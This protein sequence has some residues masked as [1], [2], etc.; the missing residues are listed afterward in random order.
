MIFNLYPK[1][2]LRCRL[3]LFIAATAFVVAGTS[4]AEPDG[5]P[6]AADPAAKRRPAET[7]AVL[8]LDDELEPFVPI[9]AR[10]ETEAERIEALSLFAAGRVD[11]QEDR[12]YQA[13][14]RYQRATRF[15]PSSQAARLQAVVLAIRLG[16]D[17]SPD[18][19]KE[20]HWN[21]ALRYAAASDLGI[22]EAGVLWKIA[23]HFAQREQYAEALRY[24]RSARELQDKRS[25]GYVILS[26]DVGR[27]AV[28]TSDF[29][30]AADVFTEVADALE[31]PDQY[32]LDEG[33]KRRLLGGKDSS[34]GLSQL[35]QLFAEAYLSAQRFDEAVASL[36]KA[37]E[38]KPDAA[39]H[40]FRLARVEDVRKQPAKSLELLKRY[41]S[42]KASSQGLAPYQLYVKLQND[43]SRGNDVISGLAELHER[44]PDN[45]LLAFFLAE[46]YRAAEQFDKAQPLYTAV[47][48]KSPSSDAYQGLAA[49]ERRLKQIANL[50]SLL[51]D[52]AGKTGSLEALEGETKAIVGDSELVASLVQLARDRHTADADNL[53]FGER[54]AVAIIALEAEQFDVAKEFFELAM[55]VNRDRASA[56]YRTWAIG[57]F[58]E[59]RYA[60]AVSVF[61]RA[62]DE[63]AVASGDP[64]FHFLLSRALAADRKLDEALIAAKHV[65]SLAPQ[66]LR[67]ATWLA[68]VLSLSKQYDEAKATCERTLRRHDEDDQSD[69]ARQLLRQLRIMLSNIAVI[70]HDLPASEE[71]L[72]QV[73]D[74]FPDDVGAQNDLGYLWADGGKHLKMAQGMIERAVAAEPDNAAY[75]DSLGW[76]YYRLGRYDDAVAEL[77]KAAAGDEPDGVMLEH[78]GDAC[79][80]AGQRDA[81]RDAWQKG[82]AALEKGDDAEKLAQ[83]KQKLADLEKP[84]NVKDNER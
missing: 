50:V 22:D 43:L 67:A 44:D 46:R 16:D 13:L 6:D 52:V 72:S 79:L 61:K 14:R 15:D 32:G 28:L 48:A 40:A 59:E 51:G 41:F 70:Q 18:R 78:L 65:A 17:D 7:A 11:E 42:E 1:A 55:K 47:L 75:R 8:D 82:L 58:G 84:A 20:G 68:Q 4:R 29:A 9:R 3:A 12:T 77:S 33:L 80:A 69:D 76:I 45:Q 10:S 36:E 21:A 53:S 5:A 71:W 60:D 54:L 35:Y 26:L 57:L 74:E 2:A 81:A 38:A 31:H 73:L 49:T 56:V 39:S 27:M 30:A 83:I 64:D 24:F 25:T 23:R 63:R 66:N 62:I 37:N 34:V 19:E